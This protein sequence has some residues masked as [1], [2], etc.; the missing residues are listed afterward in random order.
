MSHSSDSSNEGVAE[1]DED[2]NKVHGGLETC[3]AGNKAVEGQMAPL[4]PVPQ[5]EKDD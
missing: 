3:G 2:G 5:D 1:G 4:L